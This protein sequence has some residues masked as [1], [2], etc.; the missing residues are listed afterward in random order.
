MIRLLFAV[1]TGM[2]LA[3]VSRAGPPEVD[4]EKTVR[5]LLAAK[6]W[7]CHDDKKQKGGLQLHS[8]E[9][10][11][12]GGESGPALV[13]GKPEQSLIITAIRHSEQL[14]MPPKDKLTAVEIAALEA[15]VKAGAVWPNTKPVTV[16]P[17][18]SV[19]VRTIT[20][21]EKAFWAYQP[22][23][24][25][26]RPMGTSRNPIDEFLD[27]KRKL[28]GLSAAPAADRKTLI[29]RLTF[30]LTGLPP[31]TAEVDAFLNDKS[32]DAWDKL[33]D[34]LLASSA[35]G[36][37]WGRRWL[38]V[39]RYADSNGMDENLAYGN[40]WRYRDYVIRSFNQDKPFNQFI[41]EQI[42][43]DLLPGGTPDEQ[44]DRLI[45]TG[46][47]VIG[48]KML[49]EDDPMKMRMDIID[50]Q[51]DT[52]GQAFLGMTFG[53]ARCHDHKF[54]PITQADYYALAGIFFST[55]S[56]KNYSVVAH[57]NERPVSSP[58]VLAAL[59]EFE[60]KRS[61]AQEAQKA[62]ERKLRDAVKLKLVEER[63][64]ATIYA[65]AA[66]ESL[67]YRE[68]Q[69]LLV[70]QPVADQKKNH[71]VLEAE[72]F[73]RGNVTVLHDGYGAGIGVIINGSKLPNTAEYDV[74]IP[75]EGTYQIALR[76]A[77]QTSRP[78]KLLIG[79]QLVRNDA[80]KEVTGSWNPDGQK[81]FVEAQVKLKKGKTTLRLECD[82]A[83]PHFDKLA[84][85][86]MPPEKIRKAG[87]SPRDLA[88]SKKLYLPALLAWTE[89]ARTW[90][91][92]LPAATEIEKLAH[93]DKGPFRSTPELDAAI[94]PVLAADLRKAKD[95][96]AT[97]EKSRP[98]VDEAMA[99]EEGKTQNIRIHLRGSHLTLGA[100]AP[101]R[102]PVV[103]AG[104]TPPAMTNG[105]G[106][107]E[108]AEW[109]ANE[110]N[111]LTAR[112]AVNRIW[113]GHFGT[114]LVRSPD[115]FGRLGERPTHPELLDYLAGEF[116]RMG[117][118]V[119]Q[120]HRLIVR[121]DAY[122]MSTRYDAEYDRKD[123]DNRLYW[124]FNR[125]RLD[126][127]ELRDGML[128]VAGI[129]DRKPGGTLLTTGNHEYVNSTGGRGFDNFALP[130]R[131]VYLPII[132]SGVFDV[133][134]A[135]DFPDPST[136]AG[137]RQQTTVPAQA[138]F[139]LNSKVADQ[140]SEAFAKSLL[141][142]NSDD[143]TRIRQAFQRVYLR[144]ASETEVARALKY[145]ASSSVSNATSRLKAWQGFCRVLLA[146]T[147]FVFVE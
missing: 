102:V 86:L 103:M 79:G 80:A 71:L 115:N 3:T 114:G 144:T 51:L 49:A 109:I 130:R 112:V 140:T 87:P 133:L 110:R 13:P 83:I 52:L 1:L 118:S 23:K 2:G 91:N 64:K 42:A 62:I 28:A 93:E 70:A 29:R 60:K 66:L 15:W 106:R 94:E 20:A 95:A 136:S 36:E 55:K 85:L 108:L 128:A 40:A 22:V 84:L 25:V 139:Q 9:A 67:A 99:V 58:A 124:R 92:Q 131:T 43:G 33:V 7:G 19:A 107:R 50:E 77:A 137:M 35:Y 46:F 57:W 90:K 16:K 61:Q 105:S 31:T 78:T 69:E 122:K 146:S 121:S 48:P 96:L 34:R 134:Q 113:L 6:C 39:V 30:D 63:K 44:A 132:R 89:R 47:L 10:M 32:A 82:G 11:L 18:P 141:E 135:N 117:W 21:E 72:K 100:E 68:S 45:G 104:E 116:V 123:P 126:A 26:S 111:P 76:Y 101:R 17:A 24:A 27:A 119:K 142:L 41:K 4:F 37:K 74:E 14:K 59:A 56:M 143:S 65:K 73:N 75:A 147:E 8:R 12:L 129:L 88:E 97:V 125:R 54:D 120:L 138:L 145:L 53:C 5:P 98:K 81:W 38:D 127:E